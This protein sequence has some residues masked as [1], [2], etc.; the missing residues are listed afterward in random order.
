MESAFSR[1]WNCAAL[2]NC[3]CHCFP[4]LLR[5]FLLLRTGGLHA[6]GIWRAQMRF[7]REGKEAH[8]LTVDSLDDRLTPV[9]RKAGSLPRGGALFSLG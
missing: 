3:T 5:Q 6:E 7:L 4:Q 9:G 2:H 8:G 1:Q